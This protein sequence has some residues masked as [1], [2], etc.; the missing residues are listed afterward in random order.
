VQTL[1]G[2]RSP[3]DCKELAY[4]VDRTAKRAPFGSDY[5]GHRRG[6]A[7]RECA[8][9]VCEH[10][11]RDAGIEAVPLEGFAV[12]AAKLRPLLQ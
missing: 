8:A 7:T 1:S 9:P 12:W 3:K 10:T 4:T 5:G 11:L 2:S 6:A